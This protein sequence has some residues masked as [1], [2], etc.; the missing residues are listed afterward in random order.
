MIEKLF[1]QKHE[2]IVHNR[3]IV[4]CKKADLQ[5]TVKALQYAYRMYE[6]FWD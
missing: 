5:R 6:D 1:D 2:G 3:P 4:M